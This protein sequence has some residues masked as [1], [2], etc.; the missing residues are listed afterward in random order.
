VGEGHPVRADPRRGAHRT[1]QAVRAQQ[2]LGEARG[3]QQ[4]PGGR[5]A[6]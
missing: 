1:L 4:P 2:G 5:G 3:H 6:R